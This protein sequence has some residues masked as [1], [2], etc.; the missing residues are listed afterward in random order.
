MGRAWSMGL[1]ISAALAMAGCGDDSPS[2]EGQEE[3]TSLGALTSDPQGFDGQ[4]V[5]LEGAFVDRRD[6][7]RPDCEPEPFDGEPTVEDTYAPFPTTWGIEDGGVRLGVVVV[8]STG[9]QLGNVP[10]FAPGQTIRLTG[11]ARHATVTDACDLSR[12][13]QSVYLEIA[14]E[15]AGIEEPDL[16]DD[17]PDDN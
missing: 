12:A 7:P 16:P 6:E 5:T 8:T 3:V 17:P 14:P 11:T 13:F 1:V 2:G 4:Q 9:T 10:D 15:E